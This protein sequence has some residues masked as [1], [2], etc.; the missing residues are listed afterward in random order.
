MEILCPPEILLKSIDDRVSYYRNKVTIEHPSLV[1]ARDELLWA[2]LD[3]SPGSIILLYGPT[4]VGKTTLQNIV[5]DSLLEFLR[6]DLERNPGR[7]PFVRIHVKNPSC[8]NFD[9]KDYFRGLLEIICEPLIDHKDDTHRWEDILNEYRELISNYR[10][11]GSKFRTAA[12]AAIKRRKPL[13]LLLDDA[14]HFG[15][16]RSGRSVLDQL[17]TL[18][19]VSDQT[20]VTQVLGG[21]YEL[22]PFRNLNGQLSRRSIDIHFK[23]YDAED[24]EQ[25]QCFVNALGTFQA[26]LPLREPPDLVSNWD[27]FYERSLGCVGILKDWLTRSLSLALREGK[28]TLNRQHLEHRALS[29]SQ[30]AEILSEITSGEEELLETEEKRL[31]LRG[32]LKLDIVNAS[33]MPSNTKKGFDKQ[34]GKK[35]GKAKGRVGRRNPVRDKTGRSR[36][37]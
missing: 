19:S 7:L 2:I 9:W 29:I 17:N 8:H 30:C 27:Y 24:A 12:E 13:V 23:R 25:R 16:V 33:D 37:E 10:S 20:H 21:T 11:S 3:S 22:L 5:A 35:D 14:Q 32:K 6:S 1:K 26:H 31:L 36:S 15:V 28:E 18:K 4:G 34:I